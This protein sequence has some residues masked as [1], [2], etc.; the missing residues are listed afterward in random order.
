MKKCIEVVEVVG[1]G[2]VKLL[3]QEVVLFCSNY[4]YAGKLAGVN[5]DCVLLENAVIVYETGA[6]S[7]PTWKDAQKLP[8]DGH[9]VQRVAIESYGAVKRS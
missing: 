2:L 3:G 4:I 6:F 8:T 1:E 9:Y 7:L 5:D